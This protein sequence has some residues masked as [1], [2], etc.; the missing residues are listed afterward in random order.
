LFPQSGTVQ[1]D[2]SLKLE[3]SNFTNEPERLAEMETIVVFAD[4][5][6]PTSRK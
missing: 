3:V 5:A 4:I 2:G 1:E 6:S